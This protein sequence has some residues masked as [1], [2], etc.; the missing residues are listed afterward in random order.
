MGVDL[1]VYSTGRAFRMLTQ[2]K[3]D[4]RATRFL[5]PV[6]DRLLS[7]QKLLALLDGLD[8]TD[9]LVCCVGLT[10]CGLYAPECAQQ[11]LVP[12]TSALAK[13]EMRSGKRK[14]RA[15][16]AQG[17]TKRV[18]RDD[19]APLLLRALRTGLQSAQTPHRAVLRCWLSRLDEATVTVCTKLSCVDS[20][21]FA[22]V[23]VT[24]D[25]NSTSCLGLS[26]Q[27]GRT[28]HKHTRAFLT[29]VLPTVAGQNWPTEVTCSCWKK[30]APPQKLELMLGEVEAYR[31]RL[32][33]DRVPPTPGP[34]A[35]PDQFDHYTRLY[36]QTGV[37]A[38][39]LGPRVQYTVVEAVTPDPRRPNLLGLLTQRANKLLRVSYTHAD[40]L[41]Q[42]ILL[43]MSNHPEFQVSRSNPA[44][45]YLNERDI[46]AFAYLSAP[47]C[48]SRLLAHLG[49]E[50]EPAAVLMHP[51]C[52]LALTQIDAPITLATFHSFLSVAAKHCVAP[53]N[54]SL[55][56]APRFEQLPPETM[57][58]VRATGATSQPTNRLLLQPPLPHCLEHRAAANIQFHFVDA[59]LPD[60]P[61]ELLA[62]DTTAADLVLSPV[63]GPTGVAHL[64]VFDES[65]TR[66]AARDFEK[67]V[68]ALPLAQALNVAVI[69][70][71]LFSL[72]ETHAILQCIPPDARVDVYLDAHLLPVHRQLGSGFLLMAMR[73]TR[74]LRNK[75]TAQHAPAPAELNDIALQLRHPGHLTLV[76]PEYT[77]AVR[78]QH[79]HRPPA[80]AAAWTTAAHA[81]NR[82]KPLATCH[83]YATRTAQTHLV[84]CT[85]V[86]PY[87]LLHILTALRRD[88]AA[89]PKKNK[90]SEYTVLLL[91]A[92]NHNT[93]PQ[94]DAALA[95]ADIAAIVSWDNI[96]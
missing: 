37:L 57:Y 8:S 93:N 75:Q 77:V 5:S 49:C 69:H 25:L 76:Y 80:N 84:H 62:P 42:R 33:G 82:P 72:T 88:I 47:R 95:A 7:G 22:P 55:D 34:P 79:P 61:A 81:P 66:H 24:V 23:F 71:H 10:H 27:T 41:D 56:P 94:T 50:P 28:S 9:A 91:A 51:R 68:K 45:F 44:V 39:Q 83:T 13:M 70:A 16:P 4:T 92:H 21:A 35:Q 32:L 58:R 29:F 60:T 17:R 46:A 96:R 64:P 18:Q 15:A 54:F 30:H 74:L 53:L 26:V 3:F 65:D 89:Q 6:P 31:T 90:I 63:P 14:R 85:H 59:Y 67:R 43:A 38:N 1:Q 78:T 52:N 20:S 12:K 48:F 2:R 87:D 73:A 11:P 36:E 86:N 40:T 19:C